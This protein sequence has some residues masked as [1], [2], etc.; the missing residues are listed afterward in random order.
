MIMWLCNMVSLLVFI[1]CLP[2]T[3]NISVWADWCSSGRKS[4]SFIK[5][6]NISIMAQTD[7]YVFA[8]NNLKSLWLIWFLIF[9]FSCCTCFWEMELHTFSAMLDPGVPGLAARCLSVTVRTTNVVKS[10]QRFLL[11]VHVFRISERDSGG[12]LQAAS[13]HPNFLSQVSLWPS[14]LTLNANQL[15]PL[16]LDPLNITALHLFHISTQ[17]H[18]WRWHWSQTWVWLLN[19][20]LFFLTVDE[21]LRFPSN[22]SILE[23]WWCCCL[24]LCPTFNIK[25]ADLSGSCAVKQQSGSPSP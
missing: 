10:L 13:D 3:C 23:A 20:F 2:H 17:G 4:S 1:T 21:N 7:F 9:S 11:W 16:H 6:W 22:L 19:F 12:H 18:F 15:W 25:V 24:H 5:E 14:S 8:V